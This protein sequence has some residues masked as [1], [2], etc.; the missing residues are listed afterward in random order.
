VEYVLLCIAFAMF[1]GWSILGL[2][3]TKCVTQRLEEQEQHLA[4]QDAGA[5]A[6]IDL[7]RSPVRRAA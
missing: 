1:V 6:A 7:S 2:Q 4:E 3:V 5:P